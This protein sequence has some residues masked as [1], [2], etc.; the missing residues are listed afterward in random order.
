MKDFTQS[1]TLTYFNSNSLL[2]RELSICSSLQRKTL[3][4]RM[5]RSSLTIIC[6]KSL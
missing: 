2:V 3:D 4:K 1:P 5:A 6:G